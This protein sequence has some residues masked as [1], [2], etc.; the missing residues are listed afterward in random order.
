M[1]ISIA[2]G[3]GG[4][5]KTTIGVNSTLSFP[6]GIDQLI[7]DDAEEPGSHLFLSPSIHQV[8]SMGIPV[9]RIDES[10]CFYYGKCKRCPRC[11]YLAREKSLDR[12]KA[13]R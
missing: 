13:K 12:V 3:K 1:I 6:K 9:P 5:G 2:S 4:T 8:T 7:D 11:H 10:R